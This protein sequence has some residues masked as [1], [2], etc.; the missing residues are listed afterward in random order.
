MRACV[1]V[2]ASTPLSAC[3]AARTWTIAISQ[4]IWGKNVLQSQACV[5]KVYRHRLLE[6]PLSGTEGM[7][8]L[9][10]RHCTHPPLG[11][12][13]CP[14]CANLVQTGAPVPAPPTPLTKPGVGSGLKKWEWRLRFQLWS[15]WLPYQNPSF[16]LCSPACKLESRESRPLESRNQMPR[17]AE[18]GEAF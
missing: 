11:I 17:G 6:P 7:W 13:L 3:R 9:S 8:A 5:L 15:H 12:A 10:L 16:W 18:M 1:D 4:H 14:A 2:C